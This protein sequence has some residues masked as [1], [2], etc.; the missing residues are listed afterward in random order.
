MAWLLAEGIVDEVIQ[1]L[2]DDLKAKLTSLDAEY[3]D[4]ITLENPRNFFRKDPEAPLSGT[5]IMAP[6]VF[7]LAPLTSLENWRETTVD[8][9]HSVVVWL[10]TQ[11]VDLENLRKRVYRYGRALFEVLVAG[12]FDASITWNMVGTPVMDFAPII[13]RGSE[14]MADVRILVDLVKQETQ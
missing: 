14:A 12:H 13:A 9:V 11:D 3:N 7:V 2:R 8:A 5:Q 6:E 10:I 1:H 4:G